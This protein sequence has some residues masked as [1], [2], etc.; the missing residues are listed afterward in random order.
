M[1]YS[2]LGNNRLVDLLLSENCEPVVPALMDFIMYCIINVVND[3][4]LYGHSPFV[5]YNPDLRFF[6]RCALNGGKC[7]YNFTVY[8]FIIFVLPARERFNCK[9]NR[10][11]TRL[12]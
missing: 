2:N 12:V 9:L 8:F 5:A 3:R 6:L 10:P 11:V 1:K 4:R 7:L